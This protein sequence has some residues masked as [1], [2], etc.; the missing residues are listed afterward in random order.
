M[1]QTI[2]PLTEGALAAPDLG[3]AAEQFHR[4]L[5][6]H[7]VTYLQARAYLRPHGPLTSERHWQAGG[8]VARHAKPGWVDSAGFK[9]ICFEKNPLVDA[10]AQS[11][12]R[13][14][15]SDFAPHGHRDMASYWDAFSEADIA[16][17]LCATAYGSGRRITSFHIGFDRKEFAPAE[18]DAIQIAALMIAEAFLPTVAAAPEE[19]T[20]ALTRRERDV[21][22]YVAEGKTDWEIGVILSLSETTARFHADN[23]RRKLGAVNRAHAVA[24]YLALGCR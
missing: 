17:A 16:D 3:V 5:H 11:L 8:F 1:L 13:Y 23:A 20:T 2:L 6:A 12:T 10:I 7:D 4:A 15:F 21:M 14:R 24:R 22:A 19:S 9:H 18:A